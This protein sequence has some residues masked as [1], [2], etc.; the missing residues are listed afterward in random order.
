MEAKGAK[1][2]G[3]EVEGWREGRRISCVSSANNEMGGKGWDQGKQEFQS[4]V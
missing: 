4:T 2:R 1:E 3:G